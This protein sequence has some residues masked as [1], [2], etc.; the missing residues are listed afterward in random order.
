MLSAYIPIKTSGIPIEQGSSTI[1]IIAAK[2]AMLPAKNKNPLSLLKDSLNL[3]TALFTIFELFDS[4]AG[5]FLRNLKNWVKK[6]IP[7]IRE[8]SPTIILSIPSCPNNNSNSFP[9]AKTIMP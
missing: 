1:V 7:P 4:Q 2:V 9:H 8:S 5:P 6:Y 3:P